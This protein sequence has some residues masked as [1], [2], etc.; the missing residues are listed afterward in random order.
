MPRAKRER[1]QGRGS[2]GGIVGDRDRERQR[3]RERERESIGTHVMC[4]HVALA[5]AKRRGSKEE[6]AGVG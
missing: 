6:G 5:L 1:E 4:R 3:E 2:R